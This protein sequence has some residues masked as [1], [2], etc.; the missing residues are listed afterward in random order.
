MIEVGLTL[1]F[2]FNGNVDSVSEEIRRR[3]E[4][5]EARFRGQQ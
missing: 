2:D 1:G 3:V 5:D 4:D